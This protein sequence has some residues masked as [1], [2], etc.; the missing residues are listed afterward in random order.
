MICPMTAFI[1]SDN[2]T[3]SIFIRTNRHPSKEELL[4]YNYFLCYTIFVLYY[5]FNIKLNHPI[6][7]LIYCVIIN[8]I[9]H[10]L[11]TVLSGCYATD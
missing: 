6:H 8:L 5:L 9:I 3:R 4:L 2:I 10:Y 11:I 1:L 7:A